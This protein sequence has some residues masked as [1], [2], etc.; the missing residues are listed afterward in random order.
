MEKWKDVK[1][2]EGFYEVSNLGRIRRK[3]GKV[4]SGIKNND[5]RFI[6]GKM[7]KQHLKRNGYLTVDLSK[8]NK[9]KTIS[10]HRIVA[11]A[12]L[13]P[14]EGKDQ[15]NHI[16]GNKTDNR[17]ENL[18]W[19]TSSENRIH[20]FKTGL[21]ENANKKKVRC[22]QLNMVF[23]SSYSAAEYINDK[24]FKNTKQVKNVAAKIRAA[25]LGIQKIAYGF[26]WN[27]I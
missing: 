6:K 23:D 15:V 21:Q 17:I 26:T 4:K 20:A 10:V 2:Y 18:E 14:I 27:Y 11:T 9:V 13:E 1:E 5:L 12:F 16:N 7:L 3:D 25:A 22:N 8:Q 19:V 24:Y